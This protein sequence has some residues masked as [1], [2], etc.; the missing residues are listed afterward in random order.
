ME[1]THEEP[2]RGHNGFFT[3]NDTTFILYHAY[4]RSADG[5]PLLNTRPLFIDD[6]GWPTLDSS[7][8]LF[9]RTQ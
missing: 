4:T 5:A 9:R 1:G 8:A 6:E 2:G 7:K 3:E